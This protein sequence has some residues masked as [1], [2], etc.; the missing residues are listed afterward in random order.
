MNSYTLL[1]CT[2]RDGGYYNSWDFSPSLVQRYL[3]AMSM[4]G[5][6]V[7][8]VGFRSLKSSGF[9]GAN[10]YSTD[11]YLAT[12][13]IP[14]SIKIAVMVNAVELVG[15]ID[16]ATT[17]VDLLFSEVSNSTVQIVRLAAHYEEVFLL[18]PAIE[19]LCQ[20]GYSVVLNVMQASSRSS[21][22]LVAL[23]KVV[24]NFKIDVLYF[25]D[26][27]GN[28]EQTD[29]ERVAIALR[30]FWHGPLGFH[31]HDNM[32]VAL[33]NTTRAIKLGVSWV[34]STVMGMGRGAGNAKTEELILELDRLFEGNY[35]LA[36]L[37]SI[38]HKD[39]SP[40]KERYGWG[41]N[42]L[43]YISAVHN[44]HP[45]YVQEMLSDGRYT[46]E[47]I[48]SAIEFLKS[49]D[50]KR[51]DQ[52][53]VH[54]ALN[55]AAD[56]KGSWT[57]DGF[58]SGRD[59]LLLASG[60]SSFDHSDA[61]GKFVERKKPI[62][63][64]LNDK[65][66]LA[67]DQVDLWAICNPGRIKMELSR[68][69]ESGRKVILPMSNIDPAIKGHL[70]GVEILDYGLAVSEGE[71]APGPTDCVLPAPLV[72]AYALA[73]AERSGCSRILMAGFD[74]YGPGDRREAE[75]IQ[76]IGLYESRKNYVPLLAIT[77]TSYPIAETSVYYP[78][79]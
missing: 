68:F 8:E 28:M 55:Y 64:S 32:F 13:T 75:I 26:S 39:F 5:V 25:A 38:V 22:E 59:I 9:L 49:V 78:V 11:E 74:G 62:V 53:A 69:I 44:I 34:D 41:A 50:S 1:D 56:S 20:L 46:A 17:K 12:F 27:F 37:M 52:R 66:S 19:H 79:L 63:I 61:I 24:S 45:S 60:Q 58:A 43:Y 4:V 51:F 40:L 57:P 7:V 73:I 30:E 3:D 47:E 70:R 36:P 72:A 31:G 29:L 48:L 6:D 65:C 35:D 21:T 23:A 2:L 76:L 33:G 71:F 14:E 67:D 15:D 10:A 16:E 18:E 77:P 42:P 54:N